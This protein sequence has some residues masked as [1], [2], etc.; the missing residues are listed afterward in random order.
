MQIA[1]QVAVV[2]GAAS[3]MGEATAR[4]LAAAGATI[5]VVDLDA[6][7]VERVAAEIDGVAC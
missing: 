3:G 5:I 7:G 6:A 4:F 2:T 1:K